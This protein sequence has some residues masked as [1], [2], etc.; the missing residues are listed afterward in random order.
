MVSKSASKIQIKLKF[1]IN[2]NGALK[3]C[4]NSAFPYLF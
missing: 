3:P 1:C 4:V 2:S